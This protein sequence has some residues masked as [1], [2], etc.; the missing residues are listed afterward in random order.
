MVEAF[1][2]VQIPQ[3]FVR[4]F[5]QLPEAPES[6]LL[7]LDFRSKKHVHYLNNIEED[8]MYKRWRA[9]LNEVQN[10]ITTIRG[11]LF[12]VVLTQP[13]LGVPVPWW[14]EL[15]LRMQQRHLLKQGNFL[16]SLDK[17]YIRMNMVQ[18]LRNI[19]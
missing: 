11:Y 12:S 6:G 1:C 14:L 2:C 17:Q 7:R 10:F 19:V 5:L 9:N 4:Q 15:R 16:G 3:K 8:A 13:L 18:L